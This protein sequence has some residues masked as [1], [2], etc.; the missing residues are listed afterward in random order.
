MILPDV[1]QV[2]AASQAAEDAVDAETVRAVY[3][4]IAAIIAPEPVT[5][6]SARWVLPD[7]KAS[8]PRRI[9]PAE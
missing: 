4:A 6:E 9:P 1:D 8:A 3:A 7:M 5:P 2:V